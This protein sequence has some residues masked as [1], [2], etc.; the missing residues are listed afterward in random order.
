MQLYKYW[1]MCRRARGDGVNSPCLS[2]DLLS[3]ND[4]GYLCNEF[5]TTYI[6]IDGTSN[7]REWLENMAW[8]RVGKTKEAKGFKNV[9]VEM[10]EQIAENT[11]IRNNV[12]L[13]GHS[14]GGAVALSLGLMLLHRGYKVKDVITFG[15]PKLGGKRFYDASR[16]AGLNHTRVV[17]RGE[18]VAKLPFFRGKHYETN[19]IVINNDIDNIVE[20]HLSYGAYLKGGLA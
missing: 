3:D 9:A 5:D 20:K 10:Y 17:M 13:T 19:L 16:D 8:F 2:V 4:Y 1:K 6:V 14:R 12:V 15:A 18:V 7:F 11:P